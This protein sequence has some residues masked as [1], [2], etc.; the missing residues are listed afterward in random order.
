MWRASCDVDA[1]HADDFNFSYKCDTYAGSSGSAVCDYDSSA[2]KRHVLG[3][4]IAEPVIE[5]GGAVAAENY[6]N[7]G[8]RLTRSNFMW[9]VEHAGE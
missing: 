6:E 2:K 3:G 1:D 7:T 4:N 5:N 8:T 9:V